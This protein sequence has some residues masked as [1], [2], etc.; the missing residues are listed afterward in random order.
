MNAFVNSRRRFLLGAV[1][2]AFVPTAVFAQERVRQLTVV[3]GFPPGG[4]TDILARLVADGMRGTY[5]QTVVV[6]NKPGAAGR[7]AVEYVKNAKNDGSVL[8]FTPAF[9]MLI[10]P[11]VYPK[12]GYDT[13]RD[14]V[15]VGIGARSM[16]CLAVGPAVP[17]SVR[18]IPAFI[19]WA[20]ANPAKASFG[21]PSGSSQHFAGQTFARAAGI[22]LD[23]I[24]YKGGAPAM[25]DLIGGHLPVNVSPVAEALPHHQAG[26]IRI[27]AVTG[28]RRSRFLPE[29]PSMVELGYKDVLFQDWLG[30][31][32]PAGTPADVAARMNSAAAA[33]LKSEA[34][35]AGLGRLGMELDL[36]TPEAFAQMVK[37]DWEHY[38]RVVQ[39]SGFKPED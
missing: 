3:V 5:A 37:A 9:P 15:P 38:R 25:T 12:L 36:A 30:L 26:T 32:A 14:F 35:V 11:H 28:A 39:A 18:T 22:K 4:A 34:G 16:L 29:V 7:I 13:L 20:R 33:A 31:F 10:S 1:A 21:A 19:E 27:L 2:A 6:D 23:Q 8:L 24:P 17:A